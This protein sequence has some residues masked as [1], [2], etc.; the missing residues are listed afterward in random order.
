MNEYLNVLTDEEDMLEL[1][2]CLERQRK[3]KIFRPRENH[4]NKWNDSEFV[5]RF[6][7]TKNAVRFVLK[8]MMLFL[9][10]FLQKFVTLR[11][12]ATGSFFQVI[13]DF[14]GIDKSAGRIVYNVSRAIA[15]LHTS[16]IRMPNTERGNN[17]LEFYNI[18]NFSRCIGLF[19]CTHIKISSPGGVD[20]EVYRNR[21]SVFSFNVQAICDAICKIQNIVCRWPGSS[22][23]STIFQNSRVIQFD[24]KNNYLTNHK[25][26]PEIL[27]KEL[28]G[29]GKR[30]P[31]LEYEIRLKL[32]EL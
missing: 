7:L 18:A 25:L 14:A 30:F 6:R 11:F 13:G 32:K 3:R 12:Y 8:Q 2:Y 5:R 21:K 16:S 29:Y 10:N 31:I 24:Q 22:H 4:S 26:E 15:R 1:I 27:L 20:A 17:S 23:D 19:D 28:S 9:Q